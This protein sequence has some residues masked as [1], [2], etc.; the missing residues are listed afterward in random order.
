MPDRGARFADPHATLVERSLLRWSA[1][2]SCST[3]TWTWTWS[4]W[5]TQ[6]LAF[7]HC[8]RGIKRDL[9]RSLGIDGK[10]VSR[11]TDLLVDLMLLRR[12][13]PLHANVGKRLVKALDAASIERL[14]SR[15]SSPV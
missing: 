5:M 13:A 1:E 14:R 3:W 12:L 4:L 8:K 11:Y 2:F 15:C 10:T 9:A 7:Y 6:A